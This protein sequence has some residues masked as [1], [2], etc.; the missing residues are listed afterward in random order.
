MQG[1][2]E[3]VAQIRIVVGKAFITTNQFIHPGTDLLPIN[4]PGAVGERFLATVLCYIRCSDIAGK[5]DKGFHE[6]GPFQSQVEA[7]AA[8]GMCRDIHRSNVHR[9]DELGEVLYL[10]LDREIG[11][12]GSTRIPCQSV[13]QAIRREYPELFREAFNI[14]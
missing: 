8:L 1:D 6:I 12:I 13:T 11:L 10:P 9:L 4:L 14:S 7:N 3:F 5:E 2:D